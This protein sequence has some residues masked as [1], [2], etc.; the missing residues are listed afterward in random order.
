MHLIPAIPVKV[1]PCSTLI[2]FGRCMHA[3]V[4]FPNRDSSLFKIRGRDLGHEGGARCSRQVDKASKP[5]G[6]GDPLCIT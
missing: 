3:R 4:L 1:L 5:L 2:A 6:D